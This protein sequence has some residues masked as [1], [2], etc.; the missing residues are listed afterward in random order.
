M[1]IVILSGQIKEKFPK[2]E[3]VT[4]S[5]MSKL[6]RFTVFTVCMYVQWWIVCPVPASAPLND[7]I[8]VEKIEKFALHDSTLVGKAQEELSR[9]T[10]YLSE[11]L[12]PLALFSPMVSEET[13][14]EMRQYL[15]CHETTDIT[16]RVGLS[17]GRYGKPYLPPVPKSGTSLADLIGPDSFS[18]IFQQVDGLITKTTKK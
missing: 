5:Q 4:K 9:H 3:I 1:K 13:K 15:L 14:D 18:F 2:A 12:L 16:K 7:L 6:E 11:E 17:Y 10:W 8:L